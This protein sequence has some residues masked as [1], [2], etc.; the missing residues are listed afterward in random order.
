MVK[1]G[2]FGRFCHTNLLPPRTTK[3]SMSSAANS[4]VRVLVDYPARTEV[5]R[6]LQAVEC[7]MCFA[8]VLRGRAIG[9]HQVM[10]DAEV[11]QR[12]SS[13]SSAGGRSPPVSWWPCIAFESCDWSSRDTRDQFMQ[14]RRS[15]CR[16]LV[17]HTDPTWS[18]LWPMIAD[19]VE[20]VLLCLSH[21]DNVAF[22]RHVRQPIQVIMHPNPM[23]SA[24]PPPSVTSIPVLTLAPP[25]MS[26]P[27]PPA[28][29]PSSSPSP[30][31]PPLPESPST[32]QKCSICLEML[33]RDHHAI[34][35]RCMHI[36][37]AHCIRPWLRNR[38]TCPLCRHQ[39]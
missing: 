20:T 31:M 12:W 30:Q 3:D 18:T 26:P 35:L 23:M 32:E 24:P 33:M 21:S 16:V 2:V 22:A 29:S 4:R 28:N 14:A 37:H 19:A 38:S 34:A 11:R 10:Q 15:G 7:G 17:V 39:V 13:G 1:Q 25:P 9:T 5:G 8:T 27:V 6:Y 36:F